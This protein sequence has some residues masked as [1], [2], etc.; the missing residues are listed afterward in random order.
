MGCR[1]GFSFGPDSYLTL[2]PIVLS[3]FVLHATF[4]RAKDSNVARSEMLARSVMDVKTSKQIA[5]RRQIHAAIKHYRAG[6]FECV[7]TLCSAAEGQIPEPK[8]PDHLF[9]K[10]QQ[11]ACDRPALNGDKDDFNFAANWLKHGWGTDEVEIDEALVVFWLNRAISKY[12]A[13]YEVGTS[14]M[15]DLFPWAADPSVQKY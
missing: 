3:D 5:A 15:A 11:A 2:L 1:T 14:E 9:R 8:S 6:E 10:I 4:A 7:I 12:R 13:A